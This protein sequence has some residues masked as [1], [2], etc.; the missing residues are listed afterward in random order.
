MCH[1]LRSQDVLSRS[2]LK[3]GQRGGFRVT[4]ALEYLFFR[5]SVKGRAVACE[6]GTALKVALL[7]VKA[8]LLK[9]AGGSEM[10]S[11]AC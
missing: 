8:E 5:D 4:T 2:S 9:V 3:A 11:S 1:E 7:P 10:A 6:S